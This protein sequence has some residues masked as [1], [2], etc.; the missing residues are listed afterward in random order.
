MRNTNSIKKLFGIT[1]DNFRVFENFS[2]NF[3]PITI[4]T[5]PNNSGKSSVIKALLLIDDN[6]KKGNLNEAG[7]PSRWDFNSEIHNLSSSRLCR[8]NIDDPMGIGLNISD[9]DYF[10]IF[11]L[12]ENGKQIQDAAIITYAGLILIQK[13][14]SVTIDLDLFK[15]YLAKFIQDQK[16]LIEQNNSKENHFNE[17]MKNWLKIRNYDD[18]SI[19]QDDFQRLEEL[20]KNMALLM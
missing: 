1:L 3:K 7:F 2:I 11:P 18:P 13:G 15:G 6:I 4:L 16:K 9:E 12:D 20:Y 14:Q 19:N 8:K 17:S 10:Y 5:G